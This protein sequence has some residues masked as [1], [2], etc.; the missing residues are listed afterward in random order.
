MFQISTI[1]HIEPKLPKVEKMLD[2]ARESQPR[3]EDLED[4]RTANRLDEIESG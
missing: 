3:E 1:T 4:K 2:L